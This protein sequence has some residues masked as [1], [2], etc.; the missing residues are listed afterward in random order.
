[1]GT[2]VK[3]FNPI[4]TILLVVSMVLSGCP[5][6]K[7]PVVI[8]PPKVT[9]W[10][11]TV[12]CANPL[13]GFTV[14]EGHTF[15]VDLEIKDDAGNFQ[16]VRR[17][18]SASPN[19]SDTLYPVN[20]SSKDGGVIEAGY[21]VNAQEH[22]YRRCYVADRW[23]WN[24]VADYDHPDFDFDLDVDWENGIAVLLFAAVSVAVINGIE[25]ILPD[26]A[27]D[28]PDP[29]DDQ[30]PLLPGFGV[31]EITRT[32]TYRLKVRAQNLPAPMISDEYSMVAPGDDCGNV[33]EPDNTPPIISFDEVD[34]E[35]NP[36]IINFECGEEDF[37]TVVEA[38]EGVSAYDEYEDASIVVT[39]TGVD[40][41][42]SVGPATYYIVYSATDTAGNNTTVERTVN[43]HDTTPP[44]ITLLGATTITLNKGDVWS[45]PGVTAV[46]SCQGSTLV[47]ITG[48]VKTNIPG[49]YTLTYTAMDPSGNIATV[50]RTVIV[51]APADTNPPVI[52]INGQSSMSI[53]CGD[54]F[55]D[56]GATALDDIDG[57]KTV[58][59]SGEVDEANPGTYTIYYI[60][61]DAAGNTAE[62][63]RVV[64]VQDTTSPSVVLRGSSSVTILQGDAWSDPGASATDLCEGDMEVVPQGVV[65][66]NVVGVY[67]LIYRV[68]DSAGNTASVQR[69]VTVSPLVDPDRDDD[70]VPDD[71]D[72][73]PDHANP[74]QL[75]TDGDGRG[76]ACDATPYGEVAPTVTILGPN[77]QTV[78]QGGVW[79]DPGVQ[80]TDD[81][82][83]GLVAQVINPPNTAV[84]GTYTVTYRATDRGGN[85]SQENRTVIVTEVP[86]TTSPIIALVGANPLTVTVGTS[87]SSVDPGVNVTDD[88]DVDVD[89]SVDVSGLNTNQVGDDYEVVYMATDDAG[90]SASV[91]RNVIVVAEDVDI[92]PPVITLLGLDPETVNVGGVW[93]DPGFTVSDNED[94]TPT[95]VVT[96][97][98]NVEVVGQ[99]LLTYTATDDAGNTAVVTRTVNVVGLEEFIFTFYPE[100]ALTNGVLEAVFGGSDKF[101]LKLA[102][103]QKP[104]IVTALFEDSSA[105]KLRVNLDNSITLIQRVGA[106]IAWE[107]VLTEA[108]EILLTKDWTHLTGDTPQD[109]Y[110][111]AGDATMPSD[112]SGDIQR[113]ISVR[114]NTGTLTLE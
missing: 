70:G 48:E 3:K 92:T 21:W 95:V 4:I 25:A 46:D 103:G 97:T 34:E 39:V 33:V 83:V 36:S 77:P 101:Y 105:I 16:P 7:P 38:L 65:D 59:V 98:V 14:E 64:N 50:T 89:V 93:S 15:S 1:M 74:D 24:R 12:I 112:G 81:L 96:G 11:S 68:T 23:Y 108:G 113:I 73:C 87:W 60:S 78:T 102:S 90:N 61:T 58:S 62:E 79:V 84:L 29:N 37:F 18:N 20:S 30:F 67:T 91:A 109:I 6:P 2:M 55:I 100:R 82:D 19:G 88:R 110:A 86:D 94:P 40:E 54:T 75:D 51:L 26:F 107:P 27:V 45:D 42:G 17:V 9:V 56:P 41:V 104:Y 69:A 99:Y 85:S 111:F 63:E 76:N 10:T 80:I 57:V 106:S 43:V 13:I 72:N 5:E 114:V 47:E 22:V 31:F 71:E 8:P 32:G 44:V 66:V 35:G 49:S 52:T 28:D 53:E